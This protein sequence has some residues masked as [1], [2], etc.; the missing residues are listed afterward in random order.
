QRDR[1]R[2]D[3]SFLTGWAGIFAPLTGGVFAGLQR[4]FR[5]HATSLTGE[6]F[7]LL[8]FAV[9]TWLLLEYR[10][11]EKPSW[12]AA[13]TV[14]FG[15]AVTES[16]AFVGFIPV[17]ITALI[18]IKGVEFFNLRFLGRTFLCGLAGLLFFLLL[19]LL[20]KFSGSKFGIWD[21]MRPSL[22]TD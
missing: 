3:F 2:S 4:T 16:W 15:A 11:N 17:F 14:V 1:E 13:A 18:W 5:P 20:A 22:H 9:I 21:L 8:L 12:L 19:P 7:D 10:L 6:M